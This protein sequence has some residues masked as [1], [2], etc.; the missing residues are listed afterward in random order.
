MRSQIAFGCVIAALGCA[1]PAAAQEGV[2]SD[3]TS[4]AMLADA[5]GAPVG[6]AT[7]TAT[8]EGIAIAVTV[9]GV[10]PGPHGVHVHAIGRCDAP[11][12]ESAGDHWNNGPEQHGLDNPRGPHAGDMPNLLVAEDGT[13]ELEFVL[14]DRALD[15]M[16]DLDGAAIVVHAAEDD[17]ITDPAGNSGDRIACGAFDPD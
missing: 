1:A 5:Q 3:H 12:F 6:M 17:Q 9:D 2:V 10:P 13:G 8:H 4:T 14:A 11:T 15:T 16:V 7:A